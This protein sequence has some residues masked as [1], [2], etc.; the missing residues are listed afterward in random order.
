MQIIPVNSVPNQTLVVLLGNQNCRLNIY[1]KYTGLFCDVY[2]NDV[3]IIGGVL[4]ENGNRIVRSVYLGF[5][6]DLIFTDTKG[7]TDPTFNG[8]G[9]RYLL[10]YIEQVDLVTL[11]FNE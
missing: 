10:F 1:Q 6:G 9:S 3:L 7:I 11:G 8:L 4:C 5:V 2:V